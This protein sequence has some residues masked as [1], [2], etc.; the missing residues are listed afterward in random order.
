MALKTINYQDY[1]R[2]FSGVVGQ[3]GRKESHHYFGKV[4]NKKPKLGRRVYQRFSRMEF[5]KKGHEATGQYV[6]S[7]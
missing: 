6:L 1:R 4:K 3:L 7:K 5:W 2:L